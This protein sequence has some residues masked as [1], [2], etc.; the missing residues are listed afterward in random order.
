MSWQTELTSFVFPTVH[1]TTPPPAVGHEA[2]QHTKVPIAKDGKPTVVTFLRH[3]GCPFAEKTFVSMRTLASTHVDV[4]FIAVSH[5][6]R[7]STDRWLQALGGAGK[8]T[9]IIDAERESY[10]A[11]GM[12]VSSFWHIFNPWSMYSA[13]TL[14]N[15]EGIWNRPT[16]SGTRWQMSGSWA[17]DAE[18]I[19]TW[20]RVSESASETTNVRVYYHGAYHGMELPGLP[21]QLS[22]DSASD[23][24][25]DIDI[26]SDYGSEVDVDETRLA[27]VL[28]GIVATA[29]KTIIYPSIDVSQVDHVS[30]LAVFAPKS[31]LP[32]AIPLAAAAL[33]N[34]L[35]TPTRAKRRASIEVEYHLRSRESWSVPREECVVAPATPS[36]QPPIFLEDDTRSPLE[37]FRTKPQKP[38]S[39]TDLVSPAWCEIQY[40]YTL[41]KFGRKPRTQAMKQGSKVHRIL[42]EQVHRIV[43]VQ[44][45]TKEDRFGLRIWNTIQGL[46]TLRETGLTRELEVW[47]VIHGQVVNGV[48]DEISYHCPDPELEEKLEKSKTVK[49]GGTL[50]LGQLKIEQSLVGNTTAWVGALVSERQVYITDVKTRGAKTVPNAAGLRPTWMQLMLYRKLLES[51]S[52]NTVDA[53]TV[54]ARYALEPL[55]PFS[56]VFMLEISGLNSDGVGEDETSIDGANPS[57]ILHAS[58]I[59]QHNSLLALWSLMISEFSQS[60]DTFSDTLRAEF[61]WSKTGEMI[62]NALTQYD[63]AMVEEYISSEMQWWKGEREA[64]GVE[65]EEAFKCRICDFVDGCGWRKAKVEEAVEKHRLRARAREKSAV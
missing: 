35:A 60:V 39:V 50:P 3:C 6:D 33:A 47:G 51:L 36:V 44:T 58:E 9:V 32:T 46:R 5:S 49:S 24:G 28:A 38:L 22:A 57:G 61:R 2:P 65:V 34:T 59:E 23:Y 10:A 62:G 25:S 48:I 18:G 26:P 43:P 63:S 1:P 11:W 40:W 21:L 7:A 13:Y 14:G 37:R 55:E 53:E 20:G 15:K 8:V 30:D 42:E 17:L 41:T 4:H 12:G 29:P 56:N 45:K 16:E 54:F 52:L 27:Q 64:Q 19:V 31:T